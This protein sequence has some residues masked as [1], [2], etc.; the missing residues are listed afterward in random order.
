MMGQHCLASEKYQNILI[1][2]FWFR[3]EFS[4]LAAISEDYT[5]YSTDNQKVFDAGTKCSLLLAISQD[6]DKQILIRDEI[7]WSQTNHRRLKQ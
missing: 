5:L 3:D 7:F 6:Y 1:Q 2:R 4:G